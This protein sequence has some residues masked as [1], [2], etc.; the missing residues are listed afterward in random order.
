MSLVVNMA[1]QKQHRI[2]QVYLRQW[3]FRND[4]NAEVLSVLKSGEDVSHHVTVKRFTAEKNL[5]D[6]TLH[7]EGFSRFFDKQSQYVESN[8]PKILQALSQNAYDGQTR[9]YLSEFISN[10]FVRQQTTYDLFKWILPREPLRKKLLNEIAILEDDPEQPLI[11]GVYEE[12]SIDPDHTL[13]SKVSAIILQAWKHF[14]QVLQRFTHTVIKVPGEM[15]LP[16]SDNPVVVQGMAEDAWLIGPDAEIFFPISKE[17]LVYMRAKNKPK[18]S[19]L[20]TFPEEQVTIASEEVIEDVILNVTVKS[21]YNFAIVPVDLGLLNIPLERQEKYYRPNPTL[22]DVQRP[23]DFSLTATVLPPSPDDP[24]LKIL[25]KKLGAKQSPII[26]AIEPDP[27]AEENDC[28]ATVDRMVESHGGKRVLGWQFW[29]GAYLMEAEFHAI[30]QTPSGELKDVSK[31]GKGLLKIVF[32]PDPKL[33]YRGKQIDNVRINLTDNPVVYD[34]IEVCRTKYRLFNRGKRGSLY[35][36]EF[37]ESL[38]SE[39][40]ENVNDVEFFRGMLVAFLD[41]G[42]NETT[43]CFCGSGKPYRSCHGLRI[44]DLKNLK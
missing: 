27:A 43:A 32:V 22:K 18:R 38:T 2:P 44:K 16:T 41:A 7:D 11:R 6:T 31:K 37:L 17:Y 9:I 20:A 36:Q 29:A 33:V 5:F 30:W 34:L 1:D 39:Q 19:S 24:S 15:Y 40:R 12:M 26:V 21:K 4:K 10:L 25:L 14:N 3:A 28:I 23:E 35:G 42:G 13:D 8:F